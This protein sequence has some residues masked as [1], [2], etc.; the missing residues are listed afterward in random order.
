MVNEEFLKPVKFRAKGIQASVKFINS[1]S[2]LMYDRLH[3]VLLGNENLDMLE[4]INDVCYWKVA[5]DVWERARL[6]PSG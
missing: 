3:E 1:L 5:R 4:D 2:V 6:W